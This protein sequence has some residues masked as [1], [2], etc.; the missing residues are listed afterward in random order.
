VG[1]VEIRGV[2][3]A[4]GS[5]VEEDGAS[6]LVSGVVKAFNVCTFPPSL[7]SCLGVAL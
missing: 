5:E 2:V 4:S 3:N 6:E 1:R 7:A